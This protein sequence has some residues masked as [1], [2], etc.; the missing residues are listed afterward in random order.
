MRYIHRLTVDE[1]VP[2]LDE[3][4]Y[5]AYQAGH[6]RGLGCS[7]ERYGDFT[8]GNETLFIKASSGQGTKTSRPATRWRRATQVE[9]ND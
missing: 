8:S 6:F 2:K 5:Q 9:L 3:F 7:W 4:L 1:A